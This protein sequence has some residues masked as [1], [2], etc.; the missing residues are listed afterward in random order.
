MV[1][2]SQFGFM[3]GVTTE[4]AWIL[5]R[6]ITISSIASCM[7]LGCFYSLLAVS[8]KNVPVIIGAGYFTYVIAEY[9]MYFNQNAKRIYTHFLYDLPVS[10]TV[11]IFA[12]AMLLTASLLVFRQSEFK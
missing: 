5:F 11:S 6:N 3:P 9:L 8:I 7:I 1:V 2:S 12:C 10:I 4:E